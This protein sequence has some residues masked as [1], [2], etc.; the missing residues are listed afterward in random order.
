MNRFELGSEWRKWDLHVHIPGGTNNDE[1]SST[2][3]EPAIDKFCRVLE[4]SDVAVFGL[5]DYFSMDQFFIIKTRFEELYP[6][7][8]KTLLPNLELRLPEHLNREG[9]SVN[10]HILFRPNIDQSTAEDFCKS[11]KTTHSVENG[12]KLSCADLKPEHFD[13]TTV[14]MT[15]IDDALKDVFGDK[16]VLHDHAL[17]IVSAKGDGIR[18][19]GK[20]KG[21]KE[22][23]ADEIDKRVD[24]IFG[25][26][27]N[28]DWFL[29]TDRLQN[30]DLKSKPKPVF[31]G[32]D[33][34]DF[35]QLESRL[36][37]HFS[38]EGESAQTTWI[39]ADPTFEGL[40]QTLIEPA[41]RVA[42]QADEPDK[43]DAYKVIREI[44]FPGSTDFPAS[45]KFN[46]NMCS[47][48]GSRSSGKSALL[49]YIA[50]AVDPA[51]TID[52]QTAANNQPGDKVGPAA[53]FPWS[54]VA[55]LERK[56]IWA[57]P[58]VTS[59]QI[60]YVPQN[61]LYQI[62][63]HPE[64]ITK[65]I[66]PALTDKY[67]DSA[68]IYRKKLDEVA[69]C[70]KSIDD[71]VTNWFERNSE[72]EGLL[73]QLKNL[74]D[75]TAIINAR[76]ALAAEIEVLKKDSTLTAA[77]IETYRLLSEQLGRLSSDQ[78]EAESHLEL[79]EPFVF[80]DPAGA[81]T[82]IPAALSID[83]NIAPDI[84]ELPPALLAALSTKIQEFKEQLV[85][86]LETELV[87][88]GTQWSES[89]TR[90]ATEHAR[91]TRENTDLIVR[92]QA[93][94]QMEKVLKKQKAE[95]DKIAAIEKKNDEITKKRA[96][97]DLEA[98]TITA[99]LQERSNCLD[100]I[101]AD[102]NLSERTIDELTIGIEKGIDPQRL[103]ELG[104]SLNKNSGSRWIEKGEDSLPQLNLPAIQSDPGPFLLDIA[105]NIQKLNRGFGKPTVTA[106]IFKA[107]EEIRFNAVL[108]EDRIG[109]FSAS[110]MTPGKQA[111]FALTLILNE[112]QETWPLLIDQP[113]DDLDSRSIYEAIVPYLMKRKKERQI[114]MVSH[115][116]NLVMGA[117]SEQIIVANRHGSDRPNQ[118]K[119]TF[120]YRSG[121]LE[122]SVPRKSKSRFTL[123]Q[124]G[125]SEH[126]CLILDGGHDAFKKRKNKYRI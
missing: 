69:D 49:A 8:T 93:N 10:I 26:D 123:D 71:A 73:G 32:C 5:T 33:A 97:R 35:D 61:S 106:S 3:E 88:F 96:Q 82:S 22:V 19:G 113:E 21:R 1:Y 40:Q 64:A 67:K 84:E 109:G 121:S 55:A 68:K 14:T 125:T 44:Q 126:A 90:H 59:G 24:A 23:L 74:G 11:L 72:L 51:Y 29:A 98:V 16:A 115:N 80:K 7:S 78:Q 50:H 9:Q 107:T 30:A 42:I 28:R 122:H 6:Q 95:Q 63:E 12:K 38:R 105:E 65:K 47:I 79:L 108:D 60:I 45:I 104:L 87:Q 20:G 15:A 89:K 27:K 120:D 114:I 110:S 25:N 36:G 4:E 77:D 62:S 2:A 54:R 112:A 91:L 66:L 92:N 99:K 75:K 94:T 13:S 31:G 43:K 70:N 34:H 46:S 17:L 56:V 118:N 58:E 124:Q 111:L 101:L 57:D 53:A 117:D 81:L 103:A 41:D 85:S 86:A 48:I 102:F 100:E 76:D 116:A 119:H 37:K 83:V 18:P 52:Q 39:K